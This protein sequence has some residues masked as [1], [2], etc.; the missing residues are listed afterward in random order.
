MGT[1]T[2]SEARAALPEVVSRVAEGEE[3]TITRHG[4]IAAVVVRPNI[5]WAQTANA[6]ITADVGELAAALD[7]RAR[8]GGRT[9][10][11]ELTLIEQAAG[12][13]APVSDISLKLH[14]GRSNGR[15]TWSR[16]EIYGDDGR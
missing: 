11:E 2:I 16:D 4:K 3:V 8:R 6:V 9:L 12:E 7:D 13:P 10:R 5:V 15:S 14:M 1:M